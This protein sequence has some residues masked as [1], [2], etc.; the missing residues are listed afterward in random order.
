M[1]ITS[2][3]FT[4]QDDYYWLETKHDVKDIANN[5]FVLRFWSVKI[6]YRELPL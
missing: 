3:Y 5:Y 4:L 2:P 1:P 6:D